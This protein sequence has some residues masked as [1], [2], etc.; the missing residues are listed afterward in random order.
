VSLGYIKY[1]KECN[2]DY[3]D[4][5]ERKGLYDE[6]KVSLELPICSKMQ[7]IEK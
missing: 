3:E 1:D 6:T 2:A 4:M 7:R 5:N